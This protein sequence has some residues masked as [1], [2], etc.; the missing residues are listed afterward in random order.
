MA[1]AQPTESERDILELEEQAFESAVLRA[2]TAVV[3]IETFGG[4]EK[5][6][7]VTI[8]EG[9]TTGVIV[10][11]DG[12]IVSSSF[13]FIQK[14]ASILV[15]LPSGKR[16][17]AEIANRDESR[18]LVLLKVVSDEPLPVPTPVPRDEVQVGQWSLALGRTLSRD[19][20]NLSV[21]VISATHRIWGKAVQTD[22]KISPHNYG[23]AL[24]DVEGRVIGVLV[25]MSPQGNSEMAGA[26]WYD[27]G[28][29]FAVPLEDILTRLDRLKTGEPL[30]PGV[31]GVAFKGRDMYKDPAEVTLVRINSPAE[32]A[33]FQP[34]DFIIQ[35]NGR[36]VQRQAQLRHALGPLYAGDEVSMRVKRG[37][38]E[39]DLTATLTDVI[40]PYVRPFLG[41][42]PMRDS[43]AVRFVYP[44]SPAA[45]AGITAGDQI[46]AVNQ[47]PVAD[48]SELLARVRRVEP[49]TELSLQVQRG[50][51]ALEV[52]LSVGTHPRDLPAEPLPSAWADAGEAA[53]DV[54]G[55]MEVKIP[56]VANKC[57]GYVPGSYRAD[58]P[59]AL[60]VYL[61]AT[62][63]SRRDDPL[64][65][66]EKLAEEF[67]T[68]VV[69]PESSSERAW[70]ATDAEFVRKVIDQVSQDYAIDPA[71]VA[72]AGRQS[73]GAIAY[74]T[75][76][77]NAEVVRGVVPVEVGIPQRVQIPETDPINPIY[78]A[79]SAADG[80]PVAA[81]AQASIKRLDD[82]KYPL[83]L[84]P[85][86]DELGKWDAAALKPIFVWL[87]TLDRI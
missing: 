50:D 65:A 5:V 26:E 7:N 51:E 2:A 44:D 32:A 42:L 73:G 18:H 37:D 49:E 71:R 80:K 70:R 41:V 39:L 28:I 3:R 69:C 72:I 34:G 66:M 61:H 43:A 78:I 57:Q 10:S 46:T 23:G 79:T 36:P 84:V 81:A 45:A 22:A 77:G 59:A 60:L 35:C 20:P 14:P 63:S 86:L 13:N 19:T 30:K 54:T 15:T 53:A 27:S 76:F 31:L 17:S 6:G 29:G 12:Y 47:M 68:I 40:P 38:E 1:T 64:A 48:F 4:L 52:K 83:T 24:V 74:L 67:A 11:A 55:R 75:A 82:L 56:E 16:V 58:R 25:P 33:G 85:A 8:S 62:G 87:D 9:P 21:G